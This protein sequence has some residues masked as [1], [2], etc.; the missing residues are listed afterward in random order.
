MPR[1]NL[2][3]WREQERKTRRREFAIAAG[4]AVSLPP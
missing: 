4:G 1:I 3:P 2:L